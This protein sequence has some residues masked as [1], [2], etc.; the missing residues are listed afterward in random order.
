MK[1]NWFSEFWSSYCQMV[2][3]TIESES[4]VEGQKENQVGRQYE[5]RE[6]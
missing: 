2:Y 5:M 1:R 4:F 6:E 3:G